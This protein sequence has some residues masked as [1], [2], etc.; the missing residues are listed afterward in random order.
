MQ[1]PIQT[2]GDVPPF[3]GVRKAYVFKPTLAFPETFIKS[4]LA[5]TRREVVMVSQSRRPLTYKTIPR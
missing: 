5:N 1:T 3:K 4:G 2:R